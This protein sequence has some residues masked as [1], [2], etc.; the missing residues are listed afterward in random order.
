LILR[1]YVAPLQE[2]YSRTHPA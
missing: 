2:T 1:I